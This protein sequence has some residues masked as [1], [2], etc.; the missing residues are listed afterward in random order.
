MTELTGIREH[1]KA[2]VERVTSAVER[3]APIITPEAL[4]T[5]ASAAR[6]KLRDRSCG[7][8]R[9]HFAL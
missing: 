3:L 4:N 7:Y 5:F 6:R 2:D 1:A 9:D 8:R